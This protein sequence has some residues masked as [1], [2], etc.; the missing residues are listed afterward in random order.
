MSSKFAV[1]EC[2][3][4]TSRAERFLKRLHDEARGVAGVSPGI[5]PDVLPSWFDE[6]LFKNGQ[7]FAKR[8]VIR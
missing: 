1:K 4:L 2:P 5:N 8:Y 7:S 6:L 3:D